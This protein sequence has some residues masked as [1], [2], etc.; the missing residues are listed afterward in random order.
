MMNSEA[1]RILPTI[2]LNTVA[3]LKVEHI[4]VVLLTTKLD[5]EERSAL[6]AAADELEGDTRRGCT[7]ELLAWAFHLVN[8]RA[9]RCRLSF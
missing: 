9:M 1:L 5:L 8:A 2:R 4:D 7:A 6:A 3:D